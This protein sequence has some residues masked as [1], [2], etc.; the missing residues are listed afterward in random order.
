MGNPH[1]SEQPVTRP[2]VRKAQFQQV[3]RD[4]MDAGTWPTATVVK[5]LIGHKPRS[6]KHSEY[7]FGPSGGE[8]LNGRQGEWRREVLEGEYGYKRTWVVNRTYDGTPFEGT[9]HY[10]Y[11]KE[12]A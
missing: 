8:L 6:N 2:Y 4:L 9:G 12:T 5:P 3:I 11:R 7:G 10:E 1:G